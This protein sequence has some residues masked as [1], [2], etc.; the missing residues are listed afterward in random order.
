MQGSFSGRVLFSKVPTTSRLFDGWLIEK[1][2][3][4]CCRI[5]L[6][7]HEKN[8]ICFQLTFVKTSRPWAAAGETSCRLRLDWVAGG[9][10]CCNHCW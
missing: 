9:F 1:K 8:I 2:T 5:L 10:A 3:D 4:W 7:G 6:H